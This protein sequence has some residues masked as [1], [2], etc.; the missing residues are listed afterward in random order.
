MSS[1]YVHTPPVGA[2]AQMRLDN[3]FSWNVG[4]RYRI[5]PQSPAVALAAADARRATVVLE[6]TWY[7]DVVKRRQSFAAKDFGSDDMFDLV[8]L[9]NEVNP[10]FNDILLRTLVSLTTPS[11]PAR[12]WA[13]SSV[14][15]S[16]RDGKRA[17]LEI[18]KRLLPPGHRPL[19]HH[20]EL[21]FIS[22]GV[23]DDPE[24]LVTQ[25]HECLKAID[26]SGA[27]AMDEKT[28]KRQ[29]L[30]ALD[31]EFYKEVIITP[32]RL[33]TELAKVALK[34]ICTH[35]L[36]VWW[37]AHPNGVPSRAKQA[38]PVQHV[39]AGGGDRDMRALME[40]L[41]RAVRDV[42]ALLENLARVGRDVEPDPPP[43]RDWSRDPASRQHGGGGVRFPP[44]KW[45]DGKNRKPDG[46]FHGR[47]RRFG[48]AGHRFA[49]SPLPDKGTW[50]Q[51]RYKTAAHHISFHASMHCRLLSSRNVPYAPDTSTTPLAALRCVGNV[52]TACAYVG[53]AHGESSA[54]GMGDALAAA[55]DALSA[56]RSAAAAAEAG[57]AIAPLKSSLNLGR[58][59]LEPVVCDAPPPMQPDVTEAPLYPVS[60][61]DP[62]QFESPFE[63]TFADKIFGP[64]SPAAEASLHACSIVRPLA[65][66]DA[67][68]SVIDDADS[69]SD[70]GSD[71]DIDAYEPAVTRCVRPVGTESLPRGLGFAFNHVCGMCISYSG[72]GGAGF[73]HRL[74]CFGSA[75]VNAC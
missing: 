48:D 28:A 41:D 35:I 66:C 69:D 10:I 58:I 43:P 44:S 63:T 68:L 5:A 13:E 65:V 3:I 26:A 54:T 20:E 14:R 24:P 75:R 4:G 37:C 64:I 57:G 61:S 50:P 70:C 17:L 30:A 32:L 22:F 23:D 40:G 52:M 6:S 46:K 53:V 55:H 62:A 8:D 74:R 21:L 42:S 60:A 67:E 16:P 59:P 29:L 33:D 49:A 11:S 47:N 73:P 27:G 7:V 2:T 19:R 39:A 18:A 15:V 31:P 71:G 34:E 38:L 12:R 1:S 56:L 51:S 45:R 9:D 25:F 72:F 36:E